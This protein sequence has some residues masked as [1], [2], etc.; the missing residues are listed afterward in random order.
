MRAPKGAALPLRD[1]ITSFR[2]LDDDVGEVKYEMDGVE[3]ED[4][5]TSNYSDQ[6]TYLQYSVARGHDGEP[7]L[8]LET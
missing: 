5:K 7:I 2:H 4:K 3:I 1:S 8:Y 6:S